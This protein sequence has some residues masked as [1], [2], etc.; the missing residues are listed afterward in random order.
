[1]TESNKMMSK[2][3]ICCV[4][5]NSTLQCLH[6]FAFDCSSKKPTTKSW[7][8]WC[9]SVKGCFWPLQPRVGLHPFSLARPR[10]A[11]Q[12]CSLTEVSTVTTWKDNPSVPLKCLQFQKTT[13]CV[14]KYCST[15]N[16]D[17]YKQSVFLQT[18]H[19]YIPF[20]HVMAATRY[21]FL[22][23]ATP[24]EGICWIALPLL[25]SFR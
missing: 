6:S 12:D 4:H 17:K 19:S 7:L 8:L 20:L 1:M 2:G 18:M 5:G 21:F 14:Y 15:C 10:S 11:R 16:I 23:S 22:L 9:I 24:N 25:Q 3:T 13:G